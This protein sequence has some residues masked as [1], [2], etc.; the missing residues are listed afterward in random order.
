MAG[1]LVHSHG[2]EQDRIFLQM[3]RHEA[4]VQYRKLSTEKIQLA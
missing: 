2:A 4:E 3:M 1:D